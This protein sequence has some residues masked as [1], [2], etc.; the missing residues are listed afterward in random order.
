MILNWWRQPSRDRNI[1]TIYGVIVA[2]AREPC[3]TREYGVPDT[4]DG[5]FDMIVLHLFLYVRRMSGR[6]NRWGP[7]SLCLIVSAPIW[8]ATCARWEWAT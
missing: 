4:V 8:T 5:R 3:S 6:G 7:G 1:E 2:Q